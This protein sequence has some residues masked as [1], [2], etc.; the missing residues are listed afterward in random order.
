M[1]L[2]GIQFSHGSPHSEQRNLAKS[3]P[4]SLHSQ[5]LTSSSLVPTVEASTTQL[6]ALSPLPLLVNRSLILCFYLRNHLALDCVALHT[7][8]VGAPALMSLACASSDRQP[9]WQILFWS[10]PKSSSLKNLIELLFWAN[11][12]NIFDYPLTWKLFQMKHQNP[13]PTTTTNKKHLTLSSSSPHHP[14]TYSMLCSM[15]I[16]IGL[17][18]QEDRPKLNG[19]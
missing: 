3:S 6:T 19:S 11:H 1:S 4:S 18:C 2:K 13:K 5:T 10:G 12:E 16:R 15:T 9:T 17:L 7:N 8:A 14:P